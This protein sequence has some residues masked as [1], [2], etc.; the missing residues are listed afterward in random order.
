MA[1]TEGNFEQRRRRRQPAE[2]SEKA[3]VAVA[4]KADRKYST[5]KVYV[6]NLKGEVTEDELRSVFG[7]YG[8][9]TSFKFGR[10]QREATIAFALDSVAAQAVAGLQGKDIGGKTLRV[11]AAMIAERKPRAKA[12]TSS[13]PAPAAASAVASA[14]SNGIFVGNL[15][16]VSEAELQK[17]FA[18]FGDITSITMDAGGSFA[19]IYFSSEKSATKALVSNGTDF[20]GQKLRVEISTKG[21]KKAKAPKVAAAPGAPAAA[22]PTVKKERK[23]RVKK[24]LPTEIN[25]SKVY[26]GG[27]DRGTSDEDIEQLISGFAYS[28]IKNFKRNGY[29]FVTFETPEIA[30]A[31]ITKIKKDNSNNSAL[32]VEVEKLQTEKPPR[33]PRG[34]KQTFEPNPL[35]VFVG[36]LPEAKITE[37]QLASVFP[38][39][40]SIAIKRRYAFLTFAT[41]AEVKAAIARNGST[42]FDV[43]VRVE[44]YNGTAKA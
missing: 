16:Q 5:T 6:G 25:P 36:N 29:C 30:A 28:E 3:T 34:L 35:Q 41:E 13:A 15:N 23:E 19:H 18:M 7:S 38:N 26:F 8:E 27:L 21:I 33:R 17:I 31:A 42:I 11:E 40:Q 24:E 10:A 44:G 43:V 14:P 2:K 22:A 1:E 32:V 20:Q 12:A 9:I 37:A 4:V 39:A